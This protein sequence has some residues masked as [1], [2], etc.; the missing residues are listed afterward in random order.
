MNTPYGVVGCEPMVLGAAGVT[1]LV[2]ILIS[3]AMLYTRPGNP[4]LGIAML[5]AGAIL[6]T[7]AVN[8]FVNDMATTEVDITRLRWLNT[9]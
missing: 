4:G 5:F 3:F 1:G 9:E 8:E 7:G 2:L 6:L